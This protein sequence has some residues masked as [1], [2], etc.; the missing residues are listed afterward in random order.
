MAEVVGN[1]Q[2][3]SCADRG[4]DTSGDN[5]VRYSDGG[6][7]CFACGYHQ[8][9][10]ESASLPQETVT[11][12][13]SSLL[14]DLEYRPLL[15]REISAET[16]LKFGYAIGEMGG[17]TVQV[18]NYQHN[19]HRAQKVRDSK[20]NFKF[21]GAA[22]EVGLFGQHLWGSGGRKLVITEGEIDAMSVSQMQDNKWPVVS[23]PNGAQGAAKSI[24]KELE[25]VESFDEVIFMFDM[26][27]P[28][29]DAAKEAAALLSPGKA[30]IASLPLNDPNEMLVAGRGKEILRAMWDAKPY[31]PDG[32]VSIDEIIEEAKKDLVLGKPWFLDTLTQLTYG[33]RPTEVY[34]FGAG[35][36]VGKTDFLTQ[37]IEYDINTLGEQVGVIYLE[38]P[39]V[40]TATRIAGKVAGKQF[41]VPGE[42]WTSEE[43]G[44]ALESLRGKVMFYDSFGSTDWDVIRAKIRY[45]ARSMG[46]TLFYVDHLTAMADTGSE[47]ESLEEIM[48]QVAGIANELKIIIHLVSH[49]TTPDGTP[50]E[51]GGRVMIRHFKG[52]RAIGFW[53]YFMFGLERD[54]QSE[55]EEQRTT[56][57]LRI[58]KDRYTGRSTGKLI[59]LGYDPESGMLFEKPIPT[60][61]KK[62]SGFVVEEDG[63]Y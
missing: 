48:K 5:L 25:W 7:H 41:H 57:V 59:G 24:A 46:I 6:A 31:R 60:K 43:K 35:T 11:R 9:T 50:H 32:L 13:K 2:C 26:D 53:S 14:T 18:A 40:E 15:K 36:G 62:N 23:V 21:L 33:R 17:K 10:S 28:G 63:E 58:L 3:P 19:G 30:K 56:T 27:D 55:N 12:K 1:E 29:Q 34:T 38:Q 42:D 54:Q 45:M 47:R 61:P 39:P 37:Q 22:K 8:K 51:E 44:T 52:S 20:K 4:G 16:C 49:L